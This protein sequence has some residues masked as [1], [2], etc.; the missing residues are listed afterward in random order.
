MNNSIW[1]II[2]GT[3]WWVYVLFVLLVRF[4]ILASKPRIIPFRQL[5]LLPAVFIPLSFASLYQ[6][7][8]S[9]SLFGLWA[10]ALLLGAAGG[11]LQFRFINIKAIKNQSKLYVPGTWSILIIILI[12]FAV[13]YY[14]SYESAVNPGQIINPHINVWFALLYGLFTGLFI[15]RVAYALRCLKTGPFLSTEEAQR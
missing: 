1:E 13:K 11:W 15:G 6:M 2:A 10:G 12:V 8:L 5:L 9:L 3:P 4:G 14:Y 7:H